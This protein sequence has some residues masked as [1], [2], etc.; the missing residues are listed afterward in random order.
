MNLAN[1][2]GKSNKYRP[3]EVAIN[4]W[5]LLG[6]V[7][8]VSAIVYIVNLL[9]N[10]VSTV[11]GLPKLSYLETYATLLIINFLTLIFGFKA[12]RGEANPYGNIIEFI[13]KPPYEQQ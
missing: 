1:E 7:I 9:W 3:S 4:A 5:A 6:T 12:T 8:A 13:G 11:W 2:F 10:Y